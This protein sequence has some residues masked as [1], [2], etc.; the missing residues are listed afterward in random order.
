MATERDIALSFLARVLPAE[1]PYFYRYRCGKKFMK[2]M[3]ATTIEQLWDKMSQHSDTDCY[4]ATAAFLDDKSPEA[5][6]VRSK[7]A[8]YIDVEAGPGHVKKGDGYED[9]TGAI[10]AILKFCQEVGIPWPGFVRSGHGVHA[11]WC[12]HAPMDAARWLR[13]ATGLKNA[14][15]GNG[16]LADGAV[17]ADPARILRCPGTFNYKDSPPTEVM[18]DPRFFDPACAGPYTPEQFD[19]LLSYLPKLKGLPEPSAVLEGTALLNDQTLAYYSSALD[20]IPNVG[21]R[22]LWI[23]LGM[24]IFEL[25]WGEV[26]YELWTDWCKKFSEKYDKEDQRNTWE[27]FA[28]YR[29]THLDNLVTPGT[30]IHYA[31]EAGWEPAKGEAPTPLAQPFV[32]PAELIKEAEEG[33]KFGLYCAA[34]IHKG[35][36]LNKD[37]CFIRNSY[38]NACW[39]LASL[40]VRGRYDE[41][42]GHYDVQLPGESWQRKTD[43]VTIK[44]RDLIMERCQ[45][46]DPGKGATEDALTKLCEVVGPYHSVREYLGE[47]APWDGNP[48]IDTWLTMYC[49]ACDTLLNR[50]YGATTLLAAVRRAKRDEYVPFD[51]MLVLEGPQGVGKSTVVQIL[52]T[53]WFKNQGINWQDPRSQVEVFRGCWFYEWAELQG[54][55]RIEAERIKTALSSPLDEARLAYRH[56]TDATVRRTIL[57]GTTNEEEGYLT[58]QTGAR[59][60]WCIKCGDAKFKLEDLRRDRDQLFAEACER[61]ASFGPFL[62]TPKELWEEE[63]GE[64]NG[65]TAVPYLV[66]ILS[67]VSGTVENR[68]EWVTS[69]EIKSSSWMANERSAPGL[70]RSIA[71]AMR[72]LGW[73]REAHA[74]HKDGAGHR[75]RRFWRVV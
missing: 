61:E 44:A 14:C 18:V 56:D 55:G 54:H 26:G 68:R 46:T 28:K 12:L 69:F 72:Y 41:F 7:Q 6:N 65:R 37:L 16:L 24:A 74:H 2:S 62:D 35:P 10:R 49:G 38:R 21:D 58:D 52:G 31:Q 36:E 4:Y 59:R 13:Y 63:R 5:T 8:F 43:T 48:R 50:F 33:D 71:Q 29:E 22:D 39:A 51:H 45:M 27:G 30:L 3:G 20:A 34:V 70:D 64:H 15:R 75:R 23:K 1:G 11:Y 32:P 66:D 73:N 60:Y 57:I 42:T 40:G 19:T 17:T 67:Q 53:P 25:G 9:Q 47:L